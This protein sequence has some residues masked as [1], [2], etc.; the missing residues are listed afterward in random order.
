VSRIGIY[1][2]TFDPVHAGHV[3]FALQ[4]LQA[5]QL[6]KIYFLPERRPRAKQHVEH[7]GHR[8]AMLRRAI[9]PH[10][11]FDIIE[12]VD[13]S[14]SVERTLPELQRQFEGDSLV[15]LF[16]SDVVAGLADWPNVDTLLKGAELVVGL[17]NQDDRASIHKVVETIIEEQK[18]LP[19]AVTIFPSFAPTVSSGKVREAL[20][21]RQQTEGLLKSVERYSDHNWLY[22]SLA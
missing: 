8:V 17:R 19:Q 5:A 15:F 20:R 12:L 11:Q 22:V 9:E 2:G 14:F 13:V 6:D 21:S 7:F 16:G 10:P 18:I 1:A 3:S 4:A